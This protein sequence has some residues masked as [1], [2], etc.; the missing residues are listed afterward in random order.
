MGGR[1]F[2]TQ[3]RILSDS[4]APAW[5][6]VDL[7]PNRLGRFRPPISSSPDFHRE[8]RGGL[9]I[10][11][12]RIEEC[13]RDRGSSS[14]PEI[15][16]AGARANRAGEVFFLQTRESSRCPSN[17]RR[18]F[19]TVHCPLESAGCFPSVAPAPGRERPRPTL[20]S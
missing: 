15:A 7:Q 6:T 5:L 2:G 19:L 1:R 10:S 9:E 4:F 11:P 18:S 20:L 17:G 12:A 16:F 8:R 3:S 13:F 14:R